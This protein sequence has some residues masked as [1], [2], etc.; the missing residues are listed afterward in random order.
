M[1]QGMVVGFAS[2]AIFTSG[3]AWVW[4]RLSVVELNHRRKISES[5]IFAGESTKMT[6]SLPNNKPLPLPNVVVELDLPEELSIEEIK[7]WSSPAT[8]TQ[9]LRLPTSMLWYE[10][11]QWSYTLTCKEPGFYPLGPIKMDSGDIFGFFKNST[12]HFDKNYLLVYPRIV[13]LNELGMPSNRPLGESIAGSKMFEDNTRPNGVR[14]YQQGDPLK[15]I[16]WKATVK[17][18]SMHVRTFDPSSSTTVIVVSA[19]ETMR[20]RWEGYSKLYLN[21]VI[22]ASA[23]VA[24]YAFEKG[25]KIGLFSNGTPIV[26]NRPLKIP[27]SSAPEQLNILLGALR[28]IRPFESAPISSR[29]SEY[30]RKIPYGATVAIIVALVEADLVYVLADMSKIGL[31]IVVLYVGT[32]PCP[33]LPLGVIVYEISD[34]LDKLEYSNE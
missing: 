27:P 8:R 20:R 23:S 33:K 2:I 11:I 16:D 18:Q 32:P 34:Y 29:L 5:R 22:T 7:T 6:F 24:A 25:Y 30:S 28:T 9:V 3:L 10:K 19:V 17:F 26:S 14:E 12:V 15:I 4:N 21:R 13:K 1:Q 31:K